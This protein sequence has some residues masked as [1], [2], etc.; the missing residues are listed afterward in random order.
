MPQ[1]DRSHRD[2]C[3]S[4]TSPDILA[5]KN[6]GWYPVHSNIALNRGFTLIELMIVVVVVAVLAAVAFPA[7]NNQIEKAR[8]ADAISTILDTAQ[9]LERCF[10]RNLSYEGCI[11]PAEF[12]SPDEFY[13]IT[14]TAAPTSY[15]LTAEG[16]NQ[17][18][19]DRCSPFTL[20]SLGNRGAGS[21]T[22]RCWGSR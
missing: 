1:T 13:L 2:T 8:R 16:I 10:T 21:T 14:V 11:N 4:E 6:N 7:Y 15:S 3:G 5:L 20:D 19:T 17:Q 12:D 18:A 22:D 9:R